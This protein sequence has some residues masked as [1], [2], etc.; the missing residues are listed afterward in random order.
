MTSPENNIS[1]MQ[2]E[3]MQVSENKYAG[4]GFNPEPG[5][6]MKE[7]QFRFN[8]CCDDITRDLYAI[9][10][11]LHEIKNSQDLLEAHV[12]SRL[13]PDKLAE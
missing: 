6:K 1:P 9:L 5:S 4:A 11:D 3:Q 13:S 12:Y 8:Q 7:R 2:S 10:R